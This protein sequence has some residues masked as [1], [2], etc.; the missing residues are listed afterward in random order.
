VPQDRI[1]VKVEKAWITLEGEV[2]W[3]YQK[4]TAERAVRYLTGIKGVTNLITVR[5]R[6]TRPT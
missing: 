6:P 5:A 3:F 4:E 1:Q 2:D